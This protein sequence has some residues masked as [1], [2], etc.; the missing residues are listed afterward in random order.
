[1]VKVF[2]IALLMLFGTSTY[3]QD[4]KDATIKKIKIFL[5]QYLVNISTGET[6]NNP[7]IYFNK[8]EKIID[9]DGYQ[10]PLQ[11]VKTVYYMTENG[12]NCVSF[13]CRNDNCIVKPSGNLQI[14]FAIPFLSKSN[15][16]A[17]IELINQ[18]KK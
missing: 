15:C 6:G 3:S 17:F 4:S 1:M 12:A 18:L 10:I 11:E 9:I 8:V 14:G 5:H 2:F 7:T 13:D 16:Y